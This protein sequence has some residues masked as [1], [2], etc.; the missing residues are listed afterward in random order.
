MN[1]CVVGCGYVGLVAASCFASFGMTVVCID[2]SKEK[3][4]TLQNGDIPI[5]EPGL[6]ELVQKSLSNGNLSFSSDISDAGSASAIVLAVGTPPGANGEADLSYILSAVKE[7]SSLASDNKERAIIIKSTVPVGTSQIIRD[8]LDD[9]GVEEN[10]YVVSNPEFLREGSAIFD[11]LHPDRIIAGIH[12]PKAK[13]LVETLY[14]PLTSQNIPL[15]ITD[16][17]SA[18]II[19]YASNAFLATRIAYINQI[20]DLCEACGGN[21]EVVAKGMGLDHRI[22]QHYLQPG[23]GFGGSCFPKDASAL[24]AT[25]RNY[26]VDLSIVES[27]ILANNK[28]KLSIVQKAID[29]FK[30]HDVKKVAIL[31]LAFKPD[32]DDLR[33]SPALYAVPALVSQG[34]DVKVYDPAM[35]SKKIPAL[36]ITTEDSLVACIKGADAALILTEWQQFKMLDLQKLADALS[37]KVVFDTR[38]IFDA[39]RAAHAGLAYYSLGR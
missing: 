23:P 15:L 13:T 29:I 14:Q 30:N 25:A 2:N 8:L 10:F 37:A 35:P 31:G 39:M 24:L 4:D 9:L 11:F 38:N 1:V 19:K 20:S 26:Q 17:T 3:I 28:R 22:G 27:T 34:F 6:K 33:E 7:I 16:N 12:S 36:N 5:Y 18:E 21:I 32:T